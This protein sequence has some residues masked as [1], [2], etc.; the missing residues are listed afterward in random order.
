MRNNCLPFS[1]QESNRGQ[2]SHNAHH[3]WKV[4]STG[5]H[6]HDTNLLLGFLHE[7]PSW[8]GD[9]SENNDGKKL[10]KENCEHHMTLWSYDLAVSYQSADSHA[11]NG[12]TEKSQGVLGTSGLRPAKG[13]A[14][15]TPWVH[16]NGP[17]TSSS[18]GPASTTKH[19]WPRQLKPV[20]LLHTNRFTRLKQANPPTAAVSGESPSDTPPPSSLGAQAL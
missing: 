15:I 1:N 19:K 20:A 13:P 8:A 14:T 7:K 5:L 4:A 6:V 16:I 18:S 2:E 11:N 12:A 10:E 17:R 9:T 3:G